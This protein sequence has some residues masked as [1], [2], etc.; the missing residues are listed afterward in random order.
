MPAVTE[1]VV[2]NKAYLEVGEV[3]HLE[4]V[5]TNLRDKLL[6]R[7]LF[8]LGC[9]IS[10]ALALEAKDINFTQDTIIIQNLKMCINLVCS[11]CSTRLGKC[12]SSGNNEP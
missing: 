1:G 3:K 5:A 8:H 9:R 11:Q 12:K 10:E 4:Q 6:I 2:M 7:L